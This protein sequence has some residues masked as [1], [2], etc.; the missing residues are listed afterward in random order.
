MREQRFEN[1]VE[2]VLRKAG[3]VPGRQISTNKSIQVLTAIGAFKAPQTAIDVL[4][5]FDGIHVHQHAPGVECARES[6]EINPLVAQGYEPEFSRVAAIVGEELFPLGQ[7]GGGQVFLAIG[8]SGKVYYLMESIG[9]L[10]HSF[11]EALTRLIEGRRPLTVWN[12][13][14]T[15]SSPD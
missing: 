9:L 14:I 3:W 12:I 15:K 13:D 5:E 11:D 7:I 8:Q 6:F 1:Q 10:G 4:N 2:H